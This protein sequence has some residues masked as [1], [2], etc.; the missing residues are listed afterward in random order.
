MSGA[1]GERGVGLHSE[2]VVAGYTF[3]NCCFIDRRRADLAVE[4]ADIA[5][6]DS[7]IQRNWFE[8]ARCNSKFVTVST[9]TKGR[10]T[11]RKYV[12]HRERIKIAC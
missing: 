3:F 4:S 5:P 12:L 6:S 7:G 1:E 2:I 9:R 8:E 10:T 11:A